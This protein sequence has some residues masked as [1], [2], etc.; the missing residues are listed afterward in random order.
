MLRA[1]TALTIRF[2]FMFRP[3]GLSDAQAVSLVDYLEN[4]IT[5]RRTSTHP[6]ANVPASAAASAAVLKYNDA[7][8]GCWQ[9]L[10][11]A[12]YMTA[13]REARQGA[14]R[15]QPRACSLSRPYSLYF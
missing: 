12:H 8:L 5:R 11:G 6:H 3:S 14:R 15:D 10:H 2:L 7:V 13:H 4:R 9:A 1:D